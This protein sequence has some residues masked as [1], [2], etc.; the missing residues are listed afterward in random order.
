MILRLIIAVLLGAGLVAAGWLLYLPVSPAAG[1]A[2]SLSGERWYRLS[3]DGRHLGYWHTN[4]SRDR[5]G[6][7]VFESEQRFALNPGDPVSTRTRRVFA[8]D[9]PHP[10][11]AAE[12][13]QTRRHWS[14]GINIERTSSGYQARRFDNDT[15]SSPTRL[16]WQYTLN[17]Y[18]DFELWLDASSP[19]P[20]TKRTVNTLDFERSRLISRSFEIVRKDPAGYVIANAAPLAATQ[21]RLDDR[22]APVEVM[23][24]GLFNL[25]LS[26]R[27]VALAP[28][29]ALQSASYFIPID[30]RL[31]DHTRISRLVLGIEGHAAPQKLFPSLHESEGQWL[32]T[33]EANP[34]SKQPETGGLTEETLSFPVRHPE[35]S[36]LV[37]TIIQGHDTDLARARALNSFVH[38]FLRYQPG[39]PPQPVLALLSDQRGD[40]TEFADL[41]TTLARAAG[42]PTRTVF[43]L[44]YSEAEQPAFAF[45]A[46]NELRIDGGWV[47]M[48]PTWGQ[49]R[50][51]ATHIPL[52]NDD[53][54]AL[55]LLTGPASLAFSVREVE[56]FRDR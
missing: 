55:Q 52:P 19:E 10:L 2:Q 56:H 16:S 51:D 8:A 17:D 1:I 53:S 7:W 18:L 4:T 42:I 39:A 33:L 45:H 30:R 23:I 13:R 22:Y 41:L 28:R 29:S 49:D 25:T 34:L 35:V 11:I 14:E 24:A 20:G 47:A 32:L 38:G 40:C 44:A 48:D 26:S 54:A 50:V 9:P 43:G 15:F 37:D 36:A 46:W 12:H 21:I 27:E 6:A 5:E 31:V 3:L